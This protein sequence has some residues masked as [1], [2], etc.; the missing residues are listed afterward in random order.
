MR[1]LVIG[2]GARE[3]AL[4][5]RLAQDRDV[6]E[7]VVAP[8]NPGI[9]GLA[10]TVPLDLA[11]PEDALALA[12]REQIDLTIVG[13]ELP[14]SLGIADR[15][16]SEERLLFGPTSAAAR[17][18]SSKAFAKAFMARHRIPTARFETCDSA[19]HA[20]ALVRGGTYGWPVVL[21]ADGLAAGK[22]VVIAPDLVAAEAAIVDMMS[23]RKFGAAGDRL[24][25]EECLTGPEVS[26]FAVCDGDARAAD[27]HSPGS[28]ADIRR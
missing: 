6:G 3:H 18:E 25:V 10:R 5:A 12:D 4:T 24:V 20:L 8:G 21:K 15:F 22:G 26:F 1:V 27:R 23:A 7:L 28:Q 17:L 16:A 19:D 9:A 11:R 13:P 14:L 2:G